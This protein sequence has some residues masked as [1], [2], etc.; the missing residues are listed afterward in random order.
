MHSVDQLSAQI[1]FHSIIRAGE[2]A[3]EGSKGWE[4]SPLA[5]LNRRNKNISLTGIPGHR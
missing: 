5:N 4:C 3:S 2:L 1:C